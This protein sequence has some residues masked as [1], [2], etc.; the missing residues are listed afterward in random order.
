MSELYGRLMSESKLLAEEGSPSVF[1]LVSILENP[2][3]IHALIRGPPSPHRSGFQQII[4]NFNYKPCQVIS[5][6]IVE[7]K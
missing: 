1:S 5:T 4:G 6:E 3:D 2:E 7:K